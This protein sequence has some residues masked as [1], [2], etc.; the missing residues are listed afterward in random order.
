MSDKID[1]TASVTRTELGMPDL[2]L[3]SDVANFELLRDGWGPGSITWD[4]KKV[5]SPFVH[6]DFMVS[7][8]KEQMEAPLGFRV[9]GADR[10]TTLTRCGVLM[11]AFSQSDYLV[12]FEI[13]GVTFS[14][15]CQPADMVFGDSGYLQPFH[16]RAFK[17]E[18]H[19]SVPRYPIPVVGPF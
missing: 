8:R 12:T 14:W 6:G 2:D 15:S 5:T 13:E 7:A 17:Q 19:L 4:R 16:L 18:V 9:V 11:D 10:N 3:R 1:L